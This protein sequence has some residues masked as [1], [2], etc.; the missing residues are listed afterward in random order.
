MKLRRLIEKP[1]LAGII[2]SVLATAIVAGTTAYA[3]LILQ[4]EMWLYPIPLWLFLISLLVLIGALTTILL[5]LRL[6][7]RRVF[8]LISAFQ[9]KQYFAAL[10]Q[11][12]LL[13]LTIHNLDV[14][15]KIPRG[16][17]S[18]ADQD[19]YFN[20]LIKNRHN[21]LGGI[22]VPIQPNARQKEIVE[23]VEGFAKPVVFLDAYPFSESDYSHPQTCFVGYDNAVGGKKAADT[24]IHAFRNKEITSPRILVIGGNCQ[25][26]RQ[27]AFSEAI[28]KEFPS[29]TIVL[30]E[31]GNFL[32]KEARKIATHYFQEAS[33]KNKHYDAVYCTNDEMALG[34]VDALQAFPKKMSTQICVIGYDGVEEAILTI[35]RGNTPFANTVVQD[36]QALAV[37]AVEIL[38]KMLENKKVQATTWL[39]PTL[40]KSCDDD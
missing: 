15:V 39:N 8:I 37:K 35:E 24:L 14:V 7:R 29:A 23:F 5:Q 19:Q 26:P 30:N 18:V 17:Y 16:G 32:R 12:A 31:E 21:Y 33:A 38:V 36:T 13:Q 28:R 34:V 1:I 25:R 27:T 40:Y 4:R 3:R 22:I 6:Y 11:H 9:K 20:L 2:S 10:L